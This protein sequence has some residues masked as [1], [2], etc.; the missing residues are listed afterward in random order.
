MDDP[1]EI[2]LADLRLRV[3]EKFLYD[4]DFI[5]HWQHLVRVEAILEPQMG[6]SHPVCI[7]GKRSTPPEDCGGVQR[8]LELRQQH[9]PFSL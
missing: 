4:Y 1:H 3:S 9:S 6:K 8:F 5:D 2:T 7:G